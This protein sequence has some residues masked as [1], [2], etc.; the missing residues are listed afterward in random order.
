MYVLCV[1]PETGKF[2]I[3]CPDSGYVSGQR[4]SLDEAV[5]LLRQTIIR[6]LNRAVSSSSG[7]LN[8]Q[9]VSDEKIVNVSKFLMTGG[10]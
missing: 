5:E 4:K 9:H 10:I 1:D 7:E 2:T 3:V 6:D 8:G